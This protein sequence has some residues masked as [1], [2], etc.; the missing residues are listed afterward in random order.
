MIP[1]LVLLITFGWSSA[2]LAQASFYQGKTIS[3]LVGTK[4]GDVYDLYPRLLG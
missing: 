1:I 3:V 4:A 2:L